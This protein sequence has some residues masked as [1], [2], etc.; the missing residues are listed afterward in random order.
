M[1]AWKKL[2]YAMTIKKMG[3]LPTRTK[4]VFLLILGLIIG[5]WQG[6]G[7]A[8]ASNLVIPQPKIVLELVMLL[9]LMY[10]CVWTIRKRHKNE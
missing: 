8:I 5:V 2:R 4:A 1:H 3:T 7:T 6:Y 10:T 9:T